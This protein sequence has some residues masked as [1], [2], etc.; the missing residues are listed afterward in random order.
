MLSKNNV[1]VHFNL[2]KYIEINNS[3]EC[4]VTEKKPRSVS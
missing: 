1:V 3:T 2:M 4:N